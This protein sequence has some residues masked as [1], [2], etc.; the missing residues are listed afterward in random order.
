MNEAVR[1]TSFGDFERVFG[2]LDTLS[3]ASYALQQYYLN[4]GQVAWV[5][6]A[7]SSTPRAAQRTLQGGSLPQDTLRV[8][9][10]NPGLWGENLQVAVDTRTR[11][12]VNLPGEFNLV[13]REVV[14][15]QG[16][17]QVVNSEVHRNLSMNQTSARYAISV[18]NAAS[19]LVQLDDLGLGAPP[20]ATGTNVTSA[21]VVGDPN[22]T[23]FVAVRDSANPADDG[24]APNGSALQA[25]MS[26]LDRIDPFTFNILCVPRTAN[27]T[28]SDMAAFLT[29]AATFCEAKRAFLIV[30]IPSDVG[31][32]SEMTQWLEDNAGLR[33]RNAAVY[34]PAWRLLMRSTKTGHA[35]PVPAARWPECMPALTRRGGCGRHQLGP[36]P[37]YEESILRSK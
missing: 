15:V 21:Q 17:R 12:P 14:P 5:V 24:T 36:T 18:V 7:A 6:R 1:I 4:G 27:L 3:E 32:L 23:S 8:R 13:V 30:D 29:A 34:F 2:G 33:H 31:T 9:A 20:L 28:R 35:L 37:V 10:A 19:V 16:Q 26:A 22:A 11:D 25:G